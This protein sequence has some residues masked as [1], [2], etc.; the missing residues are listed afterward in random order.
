MWT[1]AGLL[2]QQQG[3]DTQNGYC[4][5]S[6]GQGDPATSIHETAEHADFSLHHSDYLAYNDTWY[7]LFI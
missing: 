4:A 3:S 1:W 6:S 2:R 5:T 7:R